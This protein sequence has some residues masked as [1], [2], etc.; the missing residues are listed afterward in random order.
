MARPKLRQASILDGAEVAR[1][2]GAARAEMRYLPKLH[3]VAEDVAFFSEQVVPTSDVTVAELD[4]RIIGFAAVKADWLDHLYVVPE[5]QGRGV[6]GALLH[7]VMS[8]SPAGL[9][10]WAFLAND[11]ARAFYARAGFVEVLRTD[12]SGNE[13]REP[14]VQLRWDGPPPTSP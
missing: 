8:E 6:G 2:F 11:R 9:S 3:T 10:L 13:E 1:V 4:G 14:D 12:G 7:R 5:W